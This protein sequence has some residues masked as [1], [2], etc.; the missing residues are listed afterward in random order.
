MDRE[1]NFCI[2]KDN[3]PG[4][5]KGC[6]EAVNGESLESLDKTIKSVDKA[7]DDMGIRHLFS[8]TFADFVKSN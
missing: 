7:I 2:L 6:Y 5:Y 8:S 3:C 1:C 4:Y